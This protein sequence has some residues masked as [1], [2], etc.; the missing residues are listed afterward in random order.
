MGQAGCAAPTHYAPPMMGRNVSDRDVLAGSGR[1]DGAEDLAD[2]A[3]QQR[4]DTDDNNGDEDEDERVLDQTLAFF[5]GAL[6][7]IAVPF[8]GRL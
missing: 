4:Q 8:R 2:L 1:V 3:A 7:S 6:R 5:F